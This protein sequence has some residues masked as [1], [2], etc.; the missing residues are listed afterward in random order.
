M[1]IKY[2]SVVIFTSVLF[3]LSSFSSFTYLQY[4]YVVVA[5]ETKNED[6]SQ[7]R[8]NDGPPP[9]A[10][11]AC[12]GKNEGDSCGFTSPYRGEIN[13]DCRTVRNGDFACVPEGGPPGKR[14][15]ERPEDEDPTGY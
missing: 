12:S 5:E 3:I 8:P 10:K 14:D 9:E 2:F 7:R 6:E 11:Q 4:D 15:R 13:G 1:N